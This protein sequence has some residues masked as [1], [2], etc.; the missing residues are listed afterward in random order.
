ML[1]L[2]IFSPLICGGTQQKHPRPRVVALT[3][4]PLLDRSC[5]VILDLS[6]SLPSQVITQC[7]L[8]AFVRVNP[9]APAA[10]ERRGGGTH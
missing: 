9:L 2:P 5:T 10:E 4:V 3:K 8:P 6:W 1:Y 7:W